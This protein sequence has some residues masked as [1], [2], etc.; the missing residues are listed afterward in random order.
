MEYT[1]YVLAGTTP[2][3]QRVFLSLAA[4]L[5]LARAGSPPADV[6]F[7]VRDVRD[8]RLAASGGDIMTLPES[9]RGGL[10]TGIGHYRVQMELPPGLYLM[11]AVVR[12]PG[13]LL[14]SADRR[15]Q[16]T[17][18]GGTGVTPGDLILGSA[19]T[20]G[21]P[22][23]AVTHVEDGLTGALEILRPV[24]R[25]VEKRRGRRAV[26]AVLAAR[27]PR[28][29][30]R[31]DPLE[32]RDA[33]RSLSRE[34]RVEIPLGGVAPGE[35]HRAGHRQIGQRDRS[36]GDAGPH[37]PPWIRR[38]GGGEG[39]HRSYALAARMRRACSTAMW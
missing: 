22:V 31:A 17:R 30:G 28:L 35:V 32:P 19:D 14:G 12:E 36:R 8:G 3:A 38:A 33:G 16:G 27:H 23:R 2:G 5:P 7:A 13:G 26:G 34:A 6:V 29:R 18:A 1:T 11:R 21:L 25:P 39:V 24:R 15:F 4:D 37:G 20:R 10:A 9:A